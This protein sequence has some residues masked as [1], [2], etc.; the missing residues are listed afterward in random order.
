MK[1]RKR[2]EMKKDTRPTFQYDGKP[3]R[4]GGILFYT[5]INNNIFYLLRKGKKDW[6]DIGGKTDEKDK[7]IMDTIIREVVEET[8][9]V[10]LNENHTVQEATAALRTLVECSSRDI[11]Y[12]KKAKYLL[13]KVE[14]NSEIYYKNMKRFGL[15]E[16]TDD[17]EMNHYYKWTEKIQRNKIHP[18]LRYSEHFFKIFNL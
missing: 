18:R 14:L 4:A 1:K 6:G 10:L 15:K 3:V 8:N 5:N 9:N 11:F 17:W 16:Q 7:M 2:K 12:I 13:L